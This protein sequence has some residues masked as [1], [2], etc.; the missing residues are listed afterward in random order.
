[1]GENVLKILETGF[2]D[3]WKYSTKQLAYPYLYFNGLDDYQKP[4]NNLQ[5]HDFLSKLKTKCVNDE[6]TAGKMDNIKRINI[7]N[8]KK[9]YTTIFKK[10]CFFY[11]HVFLR[12]L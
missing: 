1:M 5:K 3:K 10:R 12:I 2:S 7:E 4:N 8:D 9:I 6:E 11:Q